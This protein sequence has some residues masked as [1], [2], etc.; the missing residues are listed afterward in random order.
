MPQ[1]KQQQAGAISEQY[2]CDYLKEH[3]L[4]FI[5]K[6]YR[7]KSGEID[8]IMNDKGVYVFVEVRCRFNPNYGTGIETITPSKCRRVISAAKYYLIENNIYDKID[9]RFDVIGINAL[10]KITWIKNAFCA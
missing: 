5:K 6:N 9:C 4:T 8:L 10:Q 7:V 2:A 1:T 3:G